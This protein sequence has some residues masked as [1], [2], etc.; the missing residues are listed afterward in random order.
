MDSIILRHTKVDFSYFVN[1]TLQ[2]KMPWN[3]LALNFN[4]LAVTL[5][6]TREIISILLREL[7]ALQSTLHEKEKLLEK[8]YQGSESFE[9][10]DLIDSEDCVTSVEAEQG[11]EPKSTNMKE[12]ETLDDEIEVLEVTKESINDM[13]ER[14]KSYTMHVNENDSGDRDADESMGEIDNEWYTFVKNAK[15]NERET[16][17]PFQEKEFQS[18]NRIKTTNVSEDAYH[19]LDKSVKEL[20]NE[21]YTFVSKDKNI[22]SRRDLTIEREEIVVKQT[23]ERPYQ[24]T[25][26]QKAYKTSSNLKS[27][28][29]IHT[30]EVPFECKTCKKRFKQ[31]GVLKNHERIHTGEVP[32]ECNTC[33]KRFTQKVNLMNHEKIHTGEVPFECKTC[34]KRFNQQSNLKTHERIHTGEMPFECK[35]CQKRFK[36]KVD[37]KKHERIHTGEV[38]FECKTC[39]KRFKDRANLKKHERIHTGEMPYEC[40][41]C[42][43][44]FSHQSAMK[45]HERI[46]TGEEPYECRKCG[47]RFKQSPALKYHEKHHK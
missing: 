23:K 16:E 32:Y 4:S 30:G 24:C 5:N 33:N 34:N 14:P 44:R 35:T 36:Q 39:K 19:D 26:C 46:H 8:F 40:K 42:K 1:L 17:G 41:T 28:E 13:N 31:K 29:R 10:T 9:E 21:W 3:I 18:E 6:E 15:K 2:N 25:F 12:A 37:L 20:D 7:E 22:D 38:P 43:K 47:K 45:R 11:Y 27:H